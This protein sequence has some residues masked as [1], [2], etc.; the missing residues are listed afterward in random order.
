MAEKIYCV[1]SD[2]K[3][4]IDINTGCP[5][6]ACANISD[7]DLKVIVHH[8][9]FIIQESKGTKELA[10][11]AVNT[12]FRLLKN[13]VEEKTGL[14]AYALFTSDAI[15]KMDLGNYFPKEKT[16]KETYEHI[17]DVEYVV[18]GLKHAH[19]TKRGARRVVVDKDD[20]QIV[21]ETVTM[22]PLSA[23]AAFVMCSRPDL[24]RIWVA[25]D[26][27]DQLNKKGNVN[28]TGSIY[29]CHH[30]DD[31]FVYE[32]VDWR[33]GE[34]V[35]GEYHL[36]MGMRL[37]ETNELVPVGDGTLI[38]NRYSKITSESVVGK[39]MSLIAGG[40][41]KNLFTEASVRCSEN[42]SNLSQEM[43]EKDASLGSEALAD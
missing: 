26:K 23:D 21:P 39:L 5:C 33:P 24:R 18:H 22:T 37:R 43:L 14:N 15:E 27:I 41:I 11:T 19:E 9:D 20:P 2:T 1:F 40:K 29:H 42:L 12:V 10:G 32:I 38:K 31:I 30:G 36:P 35:T 25:A 28:E 16:F 13:D 34:Y 8:G 6:S 7:L 4:K 3:E 17:G